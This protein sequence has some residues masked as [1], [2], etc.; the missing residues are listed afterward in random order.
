MVKWPRI[1]AQ[2][3]AKQPKLLLCVRRRVVCLN[4]L[5][6]GV[7]VVRG[8]VDQEITYSLRPIMQTAHVYQIHD[9]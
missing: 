1:Y 9:S 4:I 7:V 3:E 2:N 8:V 6:V 5:F